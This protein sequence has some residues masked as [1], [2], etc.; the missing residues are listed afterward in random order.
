MTLDPRLHTR[1]GHLQDL[2]LERLGIDDLPAAEAHSAHQHLDLCRACRARFQ[3]IQV[4]LAQ[5]LPQLDGVPGSSERPARSGGQVVP[6]PVR[7]QRWFM[8]GAGAVVALAAGALLLVRGGDDDGFRSRGGDLSF[9]VYRHDGQQTI[10]V[11]SGD[12]VRPGDRLGFRAASQADGY[13]LVAGVDSSLQ[14][15]PCYP[16]DPDQPAPAWQASLQPR[17]LDGAV[18]LDATP[19]QERLLLLLC[20]APLTISEIAPSLQ[21]AAASSAEQEDLPTLDEGCLQR[22]L[23]LRKQTEAA[24]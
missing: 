19:G 12:G 11:R 23:R 2:A 8:G 13:L 24:P 1:D 14:A 6:L 21:E 10:R 3:A 4:E 18:E 9:E 20:D 15:Y 22:E 17:Q 5:P 7:R 16:A